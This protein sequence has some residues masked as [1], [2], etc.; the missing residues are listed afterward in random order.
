[1]AIL[2]AGLFG[3]SKETREYDIGEFGARHVYAQR[4]R[5][6]QRLAHRLPFHDRSPRPLVLRDHTKLLRIHDATHLLGNIT[7]A[8]R[9]HRPPDVI[10]DAT[11]CGACTVRTIRFVCTATAGVTI[12]TA[13]PTSTAVGAPE[14]T[15]RS[16][17]SVRHAGASLGI[18][19]P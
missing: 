6:A 12:S 10:T 2:A 1:M 15:A 17:S 14:D 13:F 4:A 19:T 7:H 16:A 8:F 3:L 9:E 11:A 18:A 5:S